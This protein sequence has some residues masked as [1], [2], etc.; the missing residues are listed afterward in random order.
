MQENGVKVEEFFCNFLLALSSITVTPI[1]LRRING[2]A[3]GAPRIPEKGELIFSYH[4]YGQEKNVWHIKEAAITPLFSIDSA[5]YLGWSSIVNEFEH[6]LEDI[7]C[8]SLEEAK[9]IILSYRNFFCSTKLSKYHQIKCDVD[10]P[11]DYVFFPLQV[12]D[13]SAVTFSTL[14]LIDMITK[15][16]ELAK[17]KKIL[18]FIKRHPFCN[19]QIMSI[20]LSDLVSENPFGRVV[21]LNIHSLIQNARSL[22]TATSGV[23][24]EALIWGIPVYSSGVSEWHTATKKNKYTF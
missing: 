20:F 1:S 12:L 17:E 23:G 2:Y 7:N 4:S 9:A 24:F 14:C 8:L 13:D 6:Y 11:Q 5:G 21:D 16:A 22:I 3:D 15:A 10:L 18:L 19:S